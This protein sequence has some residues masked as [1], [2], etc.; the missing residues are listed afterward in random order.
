MDV[1]LPGCSLVI[2][3]DQR[4]DP[5]PAPNGVAANAG[6]LNRPTPDPKYGKIAKPQSADNSSLTLLASF[7]K[8]S[9]IIRWRLRRS[10]TG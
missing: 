8:L 1:D 7:L 10:K 4:N 5:S 9:I 6:R 3:H 2:W